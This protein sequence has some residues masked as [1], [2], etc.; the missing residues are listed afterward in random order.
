MPEPAILVVDDEKNIRLTLSRAL[1]ELGRP[2]MTAVNGED[3]LQQIE[4]GNVGVMLLDLKM[5]GMD[6]MEVLRRVAE[7]RPDIRVV[8][9]TAHGDV[10]NAVDAMRLGAVDFMQK[11]FSPDEVRAVVRGLVDRAAVDSSRA[12]SYEE[13]I[14]LA[15]RAVNERHVRAAI[16]HARQAIAR[17]STRAEAFNLLG[18]LLEITGDRTEAQKQYRVALDLDPTNRA[19]RANLERSTHGRWRGEQGPPELG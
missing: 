14:A 1:E 13:D 12:E 16:V 17:D 15:K 5:P 7:E 10:P 19:A 8:I 11:P 4:D 9:I 3:A 2:I 6:G 18:A